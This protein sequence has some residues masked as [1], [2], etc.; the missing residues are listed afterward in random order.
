MQHTSTRVALLCMAVIVLLALAAAPPAG[1][2]IGGTRDTTNIYKNVG[3]NLELGA[4]VPGQWGWSASCTL[5][6]NEPGNVIVLLAA[7]QLAWNRDPTMNKV[8][9]EPVPDF[10]WEWT[11][12]EGKGL[13]D[14]KTY[15]VVDFA[16]H[17]DYPS[18]PL[19]PCKRNWIG[20]GREDVALMWLDEQVYL[21]DG[22]LMPTSP[23]VGL[24]ELDALAGRGE[25]FTAVGYG[26][27]GWL[28]GSDISLF[29]GGAAAATWDGRNYKAVSVVTENG[30]F[31]DRYLKMSTG[32]ADGDSGGPLL[33]D[34]VIL[35][36][37]SLSS[38]RQT[39]PAYDYRLDTYS[40]QKFLSDHGL[41]PVPPSE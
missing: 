7:H 27:S 40:A 30:A 35:T 3:L 33:H 15:D 20:P 10:G 16:I 19:S 23:I 11:D 8:T 14:V 38:P 12:A 37:C 9:F 4:F 22:S 24:H 34:G 5:V 29:A 39:S 28:L 13:G 36:V 2:I 6:R 25:T 32:E 18:V 31:L 21:P 41:V 17:P 1:A 26:T